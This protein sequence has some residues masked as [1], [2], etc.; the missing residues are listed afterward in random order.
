LIITAEKVQGLFDADIIVEAGCLQ[1][2]SNDLFNALRF[3]QRVDVAYFDAAGVR[4]TQAFYHLDG[5]CFSG[6]VRAQNP[7]DL[8][9]FNIKTYAVYGINVTVFFLQII[10]FDNI[11]HI[12]LPGH[13]L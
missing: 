3:F 8:T 7:K 1:L 6:A 12:F 9:L 10:D 5:G 4:F 13:H 11:P 2:H